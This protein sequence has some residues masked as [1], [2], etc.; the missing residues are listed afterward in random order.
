LFW[1]S[2]TVVKISEFFVG[3][4]ELRSMSFVVRPPCV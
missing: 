2:A 1:L 3:I 4:V